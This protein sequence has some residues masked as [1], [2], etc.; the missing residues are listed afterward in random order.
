M[1]KDEY[2]K[3]V[4]VDGKK[5]DIGMDDYGQ[6]YFFEWEEDGEIKSQ[7]CGTYNFDY[8]SCIMY[9][10]CDE[11]RDLSRKWFRDELSKE[12]KKKYNE[13]LKFIDKNNR[14]EPEVENEFTR[15]RN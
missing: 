9:E 3:T 8:M 12:E 10:L 6:S 15:W 4:Y 2:L 5:V 1:R 14:P 11:Y 7:G 13:Y